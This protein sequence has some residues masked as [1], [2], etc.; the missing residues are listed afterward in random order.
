MPLLVH[1]VLADVAAEGLPHDQLRETAGR[2]VNLVPGDGL[3]ALVST[4]EAP[5]PVPS[6][7]NLMAHARL[8]ELVGEQATVAPMRFGVMADDDEALRLELTERR[9][10]LLGVLA[11][12]D[13]HV[14][15]RLRG[16]YA[17]QEVL[18]EVLT[19]DRRAARLRGASSMEA[20]MELG[21][22]VVAGIE[23]RRPRE[24]DRA[25]SWLGAHLADV[26]VGEA[27]DPLAAFALSLL[28]ARGRLEAFDAAVETLGD[29]LAP[30]VSLELVGPVPPF[31]FVDGSA[32]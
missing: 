29:E 23:A 28:V 26:V 25:L 14:E 1:G 20:R 24:R 13:G 9:D 32:G 30:L 22:R 31:S 2:E 10:H 8:L 21:E 17:E 27:S 12:L 7:A 6:R 16:T 11:R 5:D 19:T 18:R 15:L 4:S 3:A